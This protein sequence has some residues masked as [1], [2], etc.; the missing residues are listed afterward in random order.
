[1][2]IEIRFMMIW[3]IFFPSF[4]FLIIVSLDLYTIIILSICLDDKL[5]INHYLE[6]IY[7]IYLIANKYRIN[8]FLGFI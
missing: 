7:E 6:Y 1:M 8:Q 4:E 5:R 2:L 3:L